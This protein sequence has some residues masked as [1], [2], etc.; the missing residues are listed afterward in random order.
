MQLNH[1][2]F[3]TG[4]SKHQHHPTIEPPRASRHAAPCPTRRSTR[5]RHLRA[6]ADGATEGGGPEVLLHVP[7]KQATGCGAN[8][9]QRH[10]RQTYRGMGAVLDKETRTKHPSLV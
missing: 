6:E 4:P 5:P 7:G 8:V 1:R 2:L 3:G 9:G 10:V